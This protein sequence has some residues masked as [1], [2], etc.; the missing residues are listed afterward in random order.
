MGI[1][2]LDAHGD[3]QR[4]PASLCVWGILCTGSTTRSTTDT[5]IVTLGY[6]YR[7]EGVVKRI[8]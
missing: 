7:P 8:I 6:F 3:D 1:T 5:C 2:A 4:N